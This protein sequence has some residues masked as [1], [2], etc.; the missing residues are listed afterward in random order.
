MP[1]EQQVLTL[2]ARSYGADDGSL[3]MRVERFD[4]RER[5]RR[6]A[7]IFFPLLGGAILTVPIP[8]LHL[9]TVP[10]FLIAAFALGIARLRE[11]ERIEA[12]EGACP[13]CGAAATWPSPRRPRFP[14]TV[15]CP[16]CRAFVALAA[17]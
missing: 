16:E 13:A 1:S 15:P 10:G 11:H 6:A 12:I 9:A 4:R 17:D 8:A 2:K 14:L 3:R 7:R 5:V